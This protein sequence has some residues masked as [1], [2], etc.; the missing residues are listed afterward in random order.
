MV[1]QP[2]S[3]RNQPY[4]WYLLNNLKFSFQLVYSLLVR[5]CRTITNCYYTYNLH[6]QLLYLIVPSLRI[7]LIV[8]FVVSHFYKTDGKPISSHLIQSIK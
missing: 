6:L 3:H 2:F 4:F 8:G 1:A 5:I 7:Y